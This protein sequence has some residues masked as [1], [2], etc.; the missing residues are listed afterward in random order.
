MNKNL[1]RK[2]YADRDEFYSTSETARHLF[3]RVNKQCLNDKAIY[4]NCDGPDSEIY[5][6]LKDNFN[7]YKLK[8]LYATKYVK[9]GHGIKTAFDGV[10]ESIST[11]QGNGD[12]SSAECLDLLT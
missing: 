8:C 4:C 6:H 7:A 11:L 5:K 3:E 1:G 2:D 9:D 12:Y 10:N